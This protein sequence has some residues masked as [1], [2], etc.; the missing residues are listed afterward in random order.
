MVLPPPLFVIECD[1]GRRELYGSDDEGASD[2][3]GEEGVDL[4]DAEIED[5]LPEGQSS[6][7]KDG[8]QMYIPECGAWSRSSAAALLPLSLAFFA[9][10]FRLPFSLAVPLPP[11]F[12]SSL[13]IEMLLG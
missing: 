10:L 12:F 1:E 11:F 6:I 2:G 5:E 3:E 7:T 8:E 4:S 13:L 9:C